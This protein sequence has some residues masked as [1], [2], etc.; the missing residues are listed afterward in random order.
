MTKSF[1]KGF[2]GDY[3]V[4]MMPNHLHILC[5]VEWPSVGVGW[6]PEGTMNLK[7]VE[8]D[9]IGATGEPG[10]PDRFPYID[11]WLG[12]A[13]DSPPWTRFYIKKGKGT[14]LMTQ[15]LTND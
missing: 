14:T 11:S 7:M 2:G 1:K 6:P 15:K 4:K 9:Y 8:A 10:H 12:L 5:E 13:Q 3:V